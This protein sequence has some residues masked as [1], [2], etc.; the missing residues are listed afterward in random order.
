[1]ITVD[2]SGVTTVDKDFGSGNAG[3]TMAVFNNQLIV[4]MGESVKIWQRDTSAVWTQAT[5]STFAIALGVVGNKLWRAESINKLSNCITAPQTLA[6]WTPASPNQYAVGDTTYGV[7]TII[8]YGGVPWVLKDDGAY[9][10]DTNSQ[11]FNQAPQMANWP[12]SDNGK[13]R[14]STRLNSSHIQKSRMPSS[15]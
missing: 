14:K 8:D 11:F 2:R 12:H 4:G 6:S 13:D 3:V 9:A 5:D 7:H 1:M 15:A 10:P